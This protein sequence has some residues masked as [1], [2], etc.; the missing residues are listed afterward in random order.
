MGHIRIVFTQ[1]SCDINT[2]RTS[3]TQAFSLV[4]LSIV[5]VILGLLIGGILSGQSLIASAERRSQLVS[6]GEISAAHYTFRD[7]YLCSPG[8]CS[9]ISQ[10][11]TQI[12]PAENGNGDGRIQCWL[13]A[14]YVD[15]CR[16]YFYSLVLAQLYNGIPHPASFPK[17]EY[18]R[19]K[20]KNT[21]LYTHYT[22]RYAGSSIVG[23]ATAFLHLVTINNPWA[24]G[25]VF[26]P[27]EA[28]NLDQKF[29]D[30]VATKGIFYG[31]NGGN[32]TNGGLDLPC[33][34]TGT[35]NLT[36]T[37]KACRA[38]YKID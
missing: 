21:I 33:L 19:G 12:T 2:M 13:G 1:E 3:T 37:S 15:E 8:D 14:P 25:G 31:T 7:K 6:L 35:Y 16:T 20:M 32:T 28:W 9:N 38:L 27:E 26:T 36:E 23:E 17:T 4:E 30:G 18:Y 5:L 24:S 29:D 22:D 34:A 11:F 10:F